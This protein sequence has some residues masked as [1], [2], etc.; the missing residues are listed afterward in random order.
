MGNE[1]THHR[2]AKYQRS[3]TEVMETYESMK[4]RSAIQAVD[5]SKEGRTS[6]NPAKPSVSDF[7]CDVENAILFVVK[8]QEM[9]TKIINT[10]IMGDEELTKSK[11]HQLEQRI[12]KIFSA[13]GI[14]PSA[15]YFR[16]IRRG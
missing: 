12:G 7:I 10:Y 6:T 9:L 4:Y 14:W 1:L 5:D 15:L 2:R 13:R 11:Q 16:S 3:F 8:T